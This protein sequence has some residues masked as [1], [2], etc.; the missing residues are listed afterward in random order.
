MMFLFLERICEMFHTG[1]Y[2]FDNFYFYS[3]CLCMIILEIENKFRHDQNLTNDQKIDLLESL[4]NVF[5]LTNKALSNIT[6]KQYDGINIIDRIQRFTE[7]VKSDE[8][9]MCIKE[10]IESYLTDVKPNPKLKILFKSYFI[11]LCKLIQSDFIFF[12]ITSNRDLYLVDMK[13]IIRNLDTLIFK[14]ITD[15]AEEYCILRYYFANKL[16]L[17]I[18]NNRI[19]NQAIRLFKNNFLFEEI[20]NEDELDM[21]E[22]ENEK[23]DNDFESNMNNNKLD[24]LKVNKEVQEQHEELADEDIQENEEDK[25]SFLSDYDKR[26]QIECINASLMNL[27]INKATPNKKQ[28]EKKN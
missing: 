19:Q 25:H 23:D 26:I 28:F 22:E 13:S 18:T 27:S 6:I 3:E 7:R 10:I 1:E 16:K 20:A 12:T 17:N 2:E 4:G 21:D 8:R 14:K 15:V 24:L 5:Y 11:Y 9:F